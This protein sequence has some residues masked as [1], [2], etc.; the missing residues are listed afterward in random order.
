MN[1]DARKETHSALDPSEIPIRLRA[2]KNG[3]R[4]VGTVNP[5][6]IDLNKTAESCDEGE[7]KEEESEGFKR[8]GRPD[9][10]ADDGA[11]TAHGSRIVGVI[12]APDDEKMEGDKHEDKGGYKENME[13]VEARDSCI[14]RNG[15]AKKQVDQPRADDGDGQKN[16]V[17]DAQARA[18]KNVGTNG[19]TEETVGEGEHEES[20]ANEP[21]NFAGTTVS[22][23]E[24]DAEEMRNDGPD[25]DVGGPVVHLSHEKACADFEAEM[26]N[27]LICGRHSDAVE[28]SIRPVV[29][30]FV[31][32]AVEEQSK[33][34]SCDDENDEGVERDFAEHE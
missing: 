20:E 34:R 14:H 32:A 17:A 22:G 7:D 25:E 6:R 29:D 3:G 9:A 5:D 24:E 31:G 12:L 2:G 15:A 10:R 21:V 30:D 23:G 11:V 16:G 28:G 18:R 1:V 26:K 19:I 33:E 8:I 4:I 13:R 27:G